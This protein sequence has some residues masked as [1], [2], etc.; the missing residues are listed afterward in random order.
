MLADTFFQLVR[1]QATG[2]DAID[3]ALARSAAA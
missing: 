1:N 3:M 2:T